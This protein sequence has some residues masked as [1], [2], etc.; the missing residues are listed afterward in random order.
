MPRPARPAVREE[1]LDAARTEFA[2]RGLAHARVED[3]ARRAGISRGAFYLHVRAAS[4]AR[5]RGWARSL[6]LVLDEGMLAP[7]GR[8]RRAPRSAASRRGH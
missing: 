2:R 5:P 8:G 7:Y 4:Q 1:L 6:L 3:I